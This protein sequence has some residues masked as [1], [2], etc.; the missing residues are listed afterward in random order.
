MKVLI[1]QIIGNQNLIRQYGDGI[2]VNEENQ[3]CEDCQW[4]QEF[5]V[6]I[7]TMNY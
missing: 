5:W 1:L 2:F 4:K 6:V 7:I 3:I